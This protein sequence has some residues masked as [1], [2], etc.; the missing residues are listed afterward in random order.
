MNKF[1]LPIG[2]WSDDGHGKC[3]YFIVESNVKFEMIVNTYIDMD[4]KYKISEICAEYEQSGLT[5]DQVEMIKESGL[6]FEDYVGEEFDLEE[7]NYIETDDIAQ[8]VIDFIMLCDVRIKLKIGKEEM[9]M[10]NNWAG[11]EVTGKSGHVLSLPG[12]GLFY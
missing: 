7:N 1:K 3:E 5:K 6:K 8:L 9:P 11:Q 2:D 12:Y 10:L 4:S